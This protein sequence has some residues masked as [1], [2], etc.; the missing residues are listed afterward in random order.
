MV[1]VDVKKVAYDSSFCFGRKKN[2][3]IVS[4]ILKNMNSL[5]M[6][7]NTTPRDGNG[8]HTVVHSIAKR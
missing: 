6:V 8:I 5:Q 1:G 3:P 7:Q 4:I 2:S